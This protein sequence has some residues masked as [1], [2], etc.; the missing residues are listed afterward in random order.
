MVPP[1]SGH[2]YLQSNFKLISPYRQHRADLGFGRAAI[3]WAKEGKPA[4]KKTI[5]DWIAMQAEPE[6]VPSALDQEES[7]EGR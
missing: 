1:N 3:A 4:L 2:F 5:Q 6:T 7:S